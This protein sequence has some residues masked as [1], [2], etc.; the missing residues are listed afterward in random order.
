MRISEILVERFINLIGDR[1]QAQKQKY[2]QQVFDVLQ[3]SYASIGGIKGSGFGSPD[4]MVQQIPFWKLATKNGE[5]VAVTLYKDKQ[6]RKAVASG[7]D[8]TELGKHMLQ[9]MVAAEP[10]RS[11]SE[12]SKAALAVAMKSMSVQDQKQYLIKPDQVSKITGDPVLPVKGLP[13]S[14][15][16]ITDPA[17]LESTKLTLQRY[18]DLREYGYFREIGG[19]QK[20]KVMMGTPHQSI[21]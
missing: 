14:E 21:S 10:K 13:E 19:S 6:G 17:E 11:Y 18:P 9:N 15:W 4:E 2:K 7:T 16:P 12:K 3:R 20:F 5:L 1:D 8:G